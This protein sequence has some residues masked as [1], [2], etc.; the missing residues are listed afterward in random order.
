MVSTE[1]FLKTATLTGLFTLVASG[2][3]FIWNPRFLL[4]GSW[5]LVSKVISPLIGVI[6]NYKYS[7][8]IYNP[9]Y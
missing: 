6:G 9:S 4:R 7:Y 3:G 8:L 2:L 1:F 5:D